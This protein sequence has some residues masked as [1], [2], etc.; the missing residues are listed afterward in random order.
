M[1]VLFVCH[2]YPN[3]IPDLALHG[4]RWLM[5]AD[6]VDFPRKDCLYNGIMGLGVC[7]D[8]QRFDHLMPDDSDVD[9]QDIE[10]KVESGYFDFVMADIRAARQYGSLLLKAKCPLALIDGEDQPARVGLGNYVI[11]RRETDGSDYS[12]P[13][14]M[15]LPP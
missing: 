10:R 2:P 4:L 8:N 3:Y 9:R 14:P 15:A 11:F 12:I 6:A 1:R 5:G 13:L 7:P